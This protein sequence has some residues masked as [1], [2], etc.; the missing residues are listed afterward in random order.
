MLV[1][2]IILFN[3]NLQN[4]RENTGGFSCDRCAEGFYGEPNYGDGCEPC[5]CPETNRNFAKGCAMRN[6]KVMCICKT[7]YTGPLCDRCASGFYGQPHGVTGKCESCDCDPDGTE[8]EE[9][10]QIT[11][12]CVC[13]PGLTGKRCDRCDK[14]RSMLQ[15]GHCK[16]TV[17]LSYGKQNTTYISFLVFS[18]CDNCT[19]T[20]LDR[21]DELSALLSSGAGH[22]DPNGVPA[23]WSKLITFENTTTNLT[24]KLLDSNYA[25]HRLRNFDDNQIEKV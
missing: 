15:D 7:G 17:T 23:P 4:C 16:G 19:L 24:S 21:T 12:Q 6:H 22:L 8:S 25:I 2:L 14:S 1:S 18:V 9:C 20:L 10:D 5:P 11:G 3:F 13:Q